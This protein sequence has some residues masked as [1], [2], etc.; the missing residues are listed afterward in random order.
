MA[1]TKHKISLN[2]S[3]SHL[4]RMLQGLLPQAS[5]CSRQQADRILDMI[6]AVNRLEAD[7][8]S[9]HARDVN[10]GRREDRTRQTRTA[11]PAAGGRR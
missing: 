9:L 5:R 6:D 11:I 7:A 3:P 1:G 4:R 8:L 10:R 2:V